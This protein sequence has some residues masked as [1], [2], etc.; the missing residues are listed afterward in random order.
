MQLATC[1]APAWSWSR[2]PRSRPAGASRTAAWASTATPPRPRWARAAWPH[3]RWPRRARA[4]ASSSA[5]RAAGR[6]R[7]PGRA[8]GRCSAGGDRRRLACVAPS[9]L[10]FAPDWHTPEALDDAGIEAAGRGQRRRRAARRAP[11]LRCHRAA[12]R[13]RLPAA[14]VPVAAIEPARRRLGRRRGRARSAGAAHRPAPARAGARQ[15]GARCAHHRNRLG[16]R[17]PRGRRRGAPGPGPQGHRLRLRLR[18]QRLRGARR[19]HSV[20]PRLPGRAGRASAA[21]QPGSPPAPSAAVSEPAQAAAIV[22]SGQADQ[23]ALAR[24]LPGRPALGLA[25]SGDA[26]ASPTALLARPSRRPASA[27]RPWQRTPERAALFRSCP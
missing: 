2:P 25:S 8:A 21:P 6:P 9:A 16:R 13:A 5:M 4:S 12:L 10:P 18:E 24:P 23:V 1:R 19:A 15:P 3:A 22:A 14:P 17:R 26:A 7:C 20:R 27:S 11:G